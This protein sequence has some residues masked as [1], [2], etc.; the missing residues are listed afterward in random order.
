MGFAE[1]QKEDDPQEL[2]KFHG[3]AREPLQPEKGL[4]IVRVIEDSPAEK[5]GIKRGDILISMEGKDLYTVADLFPILKDKRG[6]ENVECQVQHGS[7]LKQTTITLEDRLFREPIG[8]VFTAGG[9]GFHHGRGFP[10]DREFSHGPGGIGEGH[11]YRGFPH[12]QLHRF[13]E[14]LPDDFDWDEIPVGVIIVD[15]ESG[16]PADKAGFE[17]DDIIIQID[18]KKL[19]F[20]SGLKE[21]LGTY[22]PG[23]MVTIV[24]Q[25]DEEE[26]SVEVT[27]GESE[28]G[29]PKLGIRYRPFPFV[30]AKD[31]EFDG[32]FPGKG[33][34]MLHFRGL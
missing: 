24:F 20:A 8:L 12:E 18:D 1:G 32:P 26:K 5:A 16:S 19:S 21:I 9:E 13:F 33:K 30:K 28:E 22:E 15:I 27:L 7:E 17:E 23:N 2:Y 3:M 25:R 6:G 14:N 11:H 10:Y 29:G 31:F 34:M 4:V